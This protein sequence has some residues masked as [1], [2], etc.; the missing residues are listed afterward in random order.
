MADAGTKTQPDASGRVF[1]FPAT[2]EA[3]AQVHM[4]VLEIAAA[5]G[6][7]QQAQLEI[8]LALQEAL[9][10]ALIHGCKKDPNKQIHCH[11]G[12][13]GGSVVFT[14]SDPGNGFDPDA[15]PDPLSEVGQ[16]RFSGRGV[17]LIRSMMDEVAYARNG[18][19]LTMRKRLR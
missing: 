17:H 9:A 2:A 14:I 7:E 8:D 19:Q 10:N 15:L 16:R 4:K 13:E 11:V 5:M 1:I 18:S 3:C 12:V 6:F